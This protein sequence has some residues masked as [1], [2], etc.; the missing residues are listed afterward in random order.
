MPITAPTCPTGS[1]GRQTSCGRSDAV[2]G[3]DDANPLRLGDVT[4]YGFN[5][6][7]MFVEPGT[8]PGPADEKALDFVAANGLNFARIPT[9]YQVWTDGFDY[10][11]PRESVL[12]SLDGYLEAC[13]ARGI[14]MSLNLHRAPGY[15]ITRQDLERHNLWID[16]IAQ[17]AFVF[18]WEGFARR[19]LGVPADH[20]GFDLVNEPPQIG[21]NGFTRENHAAL[22]RRTVAAIRAI[23]PAR[24]IV[25]DGL[26]GGNLAMPELAG[27]GVT[28][29]G[30]GYQPYPVSH[31]GAEWWEGWREGD[32]PRYPGVLFDGKRWGIDD[33][34]AFYDPWRAVERTGTSIHIGEFG[35][36]NKTPNEDALRWF[37]DLFALF[38]E[39]GWGYAMWNLEGPFGIIDHGRAGARIEQR[40]G[41]PVDVELLELFLTSRVA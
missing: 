38:R 40:D 23:D 33:I 37:G 6:Q 29:S 39:F 41:Y 27:L 21:L 34:R 4:H 15:C 10:F 35:C 31:W 2:R 22:I 28:H 8:L 3:G 19:F 1:G 11:R 25:I 26:D 12:R 14:H 13:R 7:W 30:R 9:N 32:A 5:F 17:D 18:L 20:L 16:E 36:Y 24:P